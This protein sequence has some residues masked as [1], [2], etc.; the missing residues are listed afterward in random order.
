MNADVASERRTATRLAMLAA[1][2]MLPAGCRLSEEAALV[3]KAAVQAEYPRGSRIQYVMVSAGTVYAP[4]AH[5]GST[6]AVVMPDAGAVLFI[7]EK[8]RH[9]WAHPFQLVFIAKGSGEVTTLFRGSAI[10]AFSFRR[11]NGSMVTDWKKQ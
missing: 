1:L 6:N 7:D 9:R 2:A 5:M 4:S 3:Q 8:P 11:P 10:P